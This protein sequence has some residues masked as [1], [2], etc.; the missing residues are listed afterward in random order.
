MS[1][2]RATHEYLILKIREVAWGGAMLNIMLN[3]TNIN[4]QSRT[5]HK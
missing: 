3:R 2:K 5:K 1:L 4:T